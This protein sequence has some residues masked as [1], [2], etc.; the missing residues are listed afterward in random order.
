MPEVKQ[1]SKCKAIKPLAEFAKDCSRLDGLFGW[2]KECSHEHYMRT[3]EAALAQQKQAGARKRAT[4]YHRR[5]FATPGGHRVRRKASQRC[6]R[7]RRA[8]KKGSSGTF[9]P[10]EFEA[11][12]HAVGD[13]CMRCGAQVR[14]AADH[15]VPLCKGGSNGIDNIQPLCKPCNSKKHDNSW[16]FRVVFEAT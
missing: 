6:D 12:C 13:R 11:L 2:C 15:V 5:Y 1:C 9:T 3:R 4:E 10:D 8:V 16:D 14:L 7:I